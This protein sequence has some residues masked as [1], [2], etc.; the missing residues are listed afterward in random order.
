MQQGLT[1]LPLTDRSL[2]ACTL[3]ADAAVAQAAAASYEWCKG[4]VANDATAAETEIPPA[5]G[6]RVEVSDADNAV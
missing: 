1:L 2:L 6:S 3:A 5:S 4:A